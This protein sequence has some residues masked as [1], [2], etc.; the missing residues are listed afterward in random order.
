MAKNALSQCQYVIDGLTFDFFKCRKT[1]MKGTRFINGFLKKKIFGENRPFLPRKRQIIHCVKSVQIQSYFWSVFSCI[2]SEYR[3]TRT[4]NN[5]VFGHFSRSAHNSGPALRL[6]FK[7]CTMKG[8]R[9]YMKVTL[10]VFWKKI[11]SRQVGHFG[12]KKRWVL[13]I[14][15]PLYGCF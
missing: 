9:K 10:M 3:K 6:V 13:I 11:Y 4:R 2:Q 5:S 15:G 1:W 7:F 12:L 14:L 8:V